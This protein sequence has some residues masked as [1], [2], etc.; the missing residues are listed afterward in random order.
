MDKKKRD[1]KGKMDEIWKKIDKPVRKIEAKVGKKWTKNL[2]G[3]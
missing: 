3:R 2:Y 1:K